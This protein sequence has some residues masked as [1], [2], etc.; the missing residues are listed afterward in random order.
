MRALIDKGININETC[1]VNPFG[2]VAL[3]AAY[4]PEGEEWLRQLMEY[5]HGNY[6]FLCQFMAQH[7]PQVCVTRSEGTYLAWIDCSA[8]G[9]ESADLAQLIS[10]KIHVWFTPGKEYNPAGSTFMRIN[11]A[12]PRA[13]LT[14]A[15]QRFCT[16]FEKS[17]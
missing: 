2:V 8:L 11:L 16:F 6:Q 14:E 5:V 9:M 4:S 1:D 13:I 17:C 10:E 3:Q 15:L 7:L 12:C